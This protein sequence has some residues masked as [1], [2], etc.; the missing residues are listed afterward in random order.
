LQKK[1]SFKE[2]EFERREKELLTDMRKAFH[3]FPEIRSIINV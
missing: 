3:Q 1:E 2:R